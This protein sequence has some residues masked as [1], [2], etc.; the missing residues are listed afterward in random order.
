[1]PPRFRRRTGLTTSESV[2]IL[3][4]LAAG[5]I[6]AGWTTYRQMTPN[7]PPPPI[8]VAAAAKEYVRQRKA[9]PT[10]EKLEALLAAPAAER[11]PT[12]PHALL[13]HAAPDFEL[14]D[15]LGVTH[16]L[17]DLYAKGPVLVVFYYG[18][19]CDHCVSQLFD[20]NED[21]ALFDELGATVVAL[22]GDPADHTNEMFKKHGAFRF[23]VLSDPNNR[24]AGLFG[25]YQ[26]GDDRLP[27]TLL[28]GSF[29]VDRKG[30]VQWAYRGDQPFMGIKTLVH[31]LNAVK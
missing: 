20:L 19:H 26:P 14:G 4:L 27:P 5:M 18:Y 28:H 29:V 3:F 21:L 17:K 16:R 31:E 7:D 12:Q 11:V 23:P 25:C 13:H 1:M 9:T 8:S 24:V 6:L 30:M 10:Q 15:H 2:F 22:S